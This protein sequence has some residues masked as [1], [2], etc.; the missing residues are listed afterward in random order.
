MRFEGLHHV[1]AITGDAQRNLDFYV[2]LLGQ[3]FVKRT[4][5]FDAPEVYHLYY[6]DDIGTPGSIMTFFEFPGAATGTAGDGMV[7]TVA[8]RVAGADALGYWEDRLHGAGVDA[9]RLDDGRLRFADP[10]GLTLEL[11]A[12][13]A[14]EPPLVAHAPGIPAE[15]ALQGFHGVR[16][17]ASDP[18]RSEGLLDAMGFE[19]RGADL[20]LAGTERSAVLAYDEPDDHGV[21]GAGTVHHVAWATPDEDHVAWG[22]EV[23]RAGAQPTPVIDRQYFES[24][25]FR[26][27]SGVLF[28]L[29]TLSPGF[30]VDELEE[31]LGQALKLPPQHEHLR[32]RIERRLTPIS[33]PW[34][35]AREGA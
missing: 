21:P 31:T 18:A 24:I 26:E 10:E 12:D 25:Y 22:E 29:A 3:R 8:Y 14:D 35:R 5:N 16:A 7:H 1:T 27:P 32:P 6:G 15:H 19:P 11:V 20:I 9:A 28:E 4:V 13:D 34:Q 23:A 17:Y 33:D 30:A 2:G